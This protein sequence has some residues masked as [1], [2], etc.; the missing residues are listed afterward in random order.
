MSKKNIT[1]DV[2][3]AHLRM[4]NEKQLVEVIVADYGSAK[5]QLIHFA[6]TIEQ[7]PRNKYA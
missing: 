6:G 1:V 5:D 4:I 7:S 3:A 2:A